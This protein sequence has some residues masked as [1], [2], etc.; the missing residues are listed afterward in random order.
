MSPPALAGLS[1]HPYSV[2]VH[3]WVFFPQVRDLPFTQ[4][5]RPPLW[6]PL[7]L[8]QPQLIYTCVFSRTR[9]LPAPGSTFP[10][11]RKGLG[12]RCPRPVLPITPSSFLISGCG[13]CFLSPGCPVS[14]ESV[15]F[16]PSPS[17]PPPAGL[18]ISALCCSNPWPERCSPDKTLAHRVKFSLSAW[19]SLPGP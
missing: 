1:P 17:A 13:I 3:Q 11:S 15:C 7:F 9:S 6:P 8:R 10:E 12:A 5:L 18:L 4:M 2:P 19:P 14:L 16:A